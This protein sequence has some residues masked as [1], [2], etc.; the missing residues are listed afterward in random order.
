M[1]VSFYVRTQN[2][3]ILIDGG[4]TGVGCLGEKKPPGAAPGRFIFILR[5]VL[6]RNSFTWMNFG[7]TILL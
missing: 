7:A 5:E 2:R 4:M 3:A 1:D 6:T